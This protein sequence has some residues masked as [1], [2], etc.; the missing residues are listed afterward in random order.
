VWIVDFSYPLDVLRDIAA[1]IPGRVIVIDHH[2][3]ARYALVGLSSP[4]DSS[5]DRL[6]AVFDESR[7]GCG[8]TWDT[9][10]P[11]IPRPWL[12]GY[13]EDRDLWRFALPESR[14]VN[15][16]I[17]S[18]DMSFALLDELASDDADA[19]R[20]LAHEGVAIRRYQA[21]II[22]DMCVDPPFRH[23]GT[24][25]VPCVTC[26]SPRLISELGHAL[27]EGY[28]FAAVMHE[29]PGGETRVSLRSREGGADVSRLARAFGGGGHTHAAGYT[30]P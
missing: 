12:V 14:E 17:A 5:E 25:Y 7:S 30:L 23:I 13:V 29:C 4:S 3:T 20:R 16:A 27:A 15:A 24:D 26:Q 18:Y 10:S 9:V 28:P 19:L 22:E 1:A 11:G 6:L 2:V 8:L 21:Q